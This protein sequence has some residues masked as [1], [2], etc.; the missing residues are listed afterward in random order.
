MNR[1][2]ENLNLAFQT[3]KTQT[4]ATLLLGTVLF[5]A[6]FPVAA[7]AANLSQLIA[8]AAKWESGQSQEPL[9]Q[10]EQ[11]ARDS[12]SQPAQRAE[13]E[14]ALANL[15]APT[16]TFEARRFACQ[17]LAVI[18]SDASVPAI[19]K[20]LAE[21][22][23]VGLACL[24]FGNRPSAAANETLRAAL[25][26]AQGPGR[27]QLIATLGNRR[28]PQAVA[29][30][31]GLARE[32]DLTVAQTAIRALGKIADASAYSAIAALRAGA[33]PALEGAL[34][35]ASLRC[36][37]ELVRAGDCKGAA[38]IY[39]PLI[40][41]TQPEHVRRGAFA[42]LLRCDRDGAEQRILQTLGSSDDLLKPVAIGA[43]RELPSKTASA[44]FGK[45][46]PKLP[47]EQ[48]VWLVESLAARGDSAAQTAI[49]TALTA[50]AD[51]GVRQAA[52]QALGRI[53]D[54]R[55]VKPLAQ[56]LATVSSE[57]EA[58]TI[59]A[60]LAGL[61]AGR[62]TDKAMLGELKA[63]QG[64]ERAQLVAALGARRS[65]AVYDALLNETEHADPAVAKA[66]YRV[67]AKATTW[68]T[69][70]ALVKKFI[71]IRDDSRRADAEMYMEQAVLNVE[72]PADR[73]AAVC[74][75]LPRVTELQT[76][77]A[78]LRLLPACGDDR[79]LRALKD[80]WGDP[81]AQVR[82]VA[83]SALAEWP[84][85]AA[86]EMLAYICRNPENPAQHTTALRGLA[87]LF[88]EFTA[89]PGKLPAIPAGE[90]LASATSDADLKLILGT[91]GGAAD[92]DVLRLVLPLL[93]KPAV[94]AEAEVAVKKLAEAV[95]ARHPELAKEA[96]SRLAK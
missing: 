46:L 48:Q 47:V 44:T 89:Q 16:S 9:F 26:T 57:T 64:K 73:S 65:P 6:T 29:P 50:S 5:T 60:A 83:I 1:Q 52:A 36:A 94:R 40:A 21:A 85:A 59:V 61:P 20:L 91:I 90:L 67:L 58:N 49:A 72:Q 70:P 86:W 42:G 35:D 38:A 27:L 4:I 74:V 63:A 88:S 41:S 18:G 10:L 33:N 93:G 28:D 95:K 14:A 62:G 19:A 66:A 69:L 56:A 68:A 12:A 30:L 32:A 92:P 81:E 17:Q 43:V 82:E 76:R 11:L 78:L 80:A 25:T 24:A 87:R 71:A 39:E 55:S 77:L 45:E 8:D 84:D 51:P 79:A 96:L 3:M 31:T 7:T 75:W 23:T 34:A 22:E 54:A 15:L 37:D 53:G 2:D 13:L